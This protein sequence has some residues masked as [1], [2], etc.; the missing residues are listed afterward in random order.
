LEKVLI[1]G[2]AGFFGSLL[3]E[4]LIQRGYFCVVYDLLVDRSNMP[5]LIGV[6]GD[7][8]N[9]GDLEKCILEHGPFSCVYHLAAQLA[10]EARSKQFLWESNVDGTKNVAEICLKYNIS[11]LIYTSSNCIW[12]EPLGHPVREDDEPNPKEIYGK[13]KW[14]GEKILLDFK[15]DLNFTI[16]RCPTIISAGRLG[17]LA[18]LYEFIDEDRNI[19]VIGS[20]ENIYQ[21]IYSNDLS[22]ACYRSSKEKKSEVYNIGADNVKS[23]KEIYQFIIDNSGSKSKIKSLPKL[24]AILALK[25]AHKLKISPL[26]PYHYR[27]IAE[28][29]LFDTNKIKSS[30]GWSPTKTNEEMLFEAYK[31]YKEDKEDM[32][33]TI[34]HTSPHQHK[35]DMGIIKIIKYFS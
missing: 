8:R 16:I 15:D 14:E 19:Y 32:S 21:F 23:L 6:V 33:N 9:K 11:K 31:Y 17:L 26:G 29:F 34:D 7:V 18:I 20:G 2:G 5:N 22:E 35:A 30:L 27:M 25:I 1:T 12:G 13:S 4:F 28:N 24:P 3:K 10:H